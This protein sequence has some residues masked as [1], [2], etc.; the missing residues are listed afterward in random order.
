MKL[1]IIGGIAGGAIGYAYFYFIGCNGACAITANPLS[2]TI[3]GI[4][5]GLLIGAIFK[6]DNKKADDKNKADIIVENDS[7]GLEG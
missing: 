4:V 7:I 2:S 1:C 6:K 5:F 3:Y